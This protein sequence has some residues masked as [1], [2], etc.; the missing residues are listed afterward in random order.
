MVEI[1]FFSLISMAI[2]F[3]GAYWL[4]IK[5]IEKR[6]QESEVEVKRIS[7]EAKHKAERILREAQ[8]EAKDI[9]FRMKNDFDIETRETRSELK[10]KE[11]M[12][13]S[14]RREYRSKD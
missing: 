7:D 3:V 14:E 11:K 1:I 9:L 4:K 13:K 5:N 8:I 12:V 10:K 2:G 6:A